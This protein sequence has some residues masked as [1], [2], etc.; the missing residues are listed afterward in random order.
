MIGRIAGPLAGPCAAF[1]S[2]FRWANFDVFP[3]IKFYPEPAGGII[4]GDCGNYVMNAFLMRLCQL[5]SSLLIV[6]VWREAVRR[7]FISR[8]PGTDVLP[9]ILCFPNVEVPAMLTMIYPLTD[10]I[11]RA[12]E[13][14]CTNW[15]I[16]ACIIFAFPVL[17]LLLGAFARAMYMHRTRKAE[18]VPPSLLEEP[19][20]QSAWGFFAVEGFRKVVMALILGLTVDEARAVL[21]CMMFGAYLGL[22][23]FFLPMQNRLFM[24]QCAL[25][26]CADTISVVFAA[27]PV[28]GWTDTGMASSNAIIFA[29]LSLMTSCAGLVS[30]S[31]ISLTPYAAKL[32]D[33]Y[34]EELDLTILSVMVDG[35]GASQGPA[36]PEVQRANTLRKSNHG[37]SVNPVMSENPLFPARCCYPILLANFLASHCRNEVDVLY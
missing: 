30:V 36:S 33:A 13:T 3:W 26:G 32:M 37:D 17:L 4:D 16:T 2:G 31:I 6:F 12:I 20:K 25:I 27:S 35:D 14:E 11:A 10:V 9:A 19:Y 5:S 7:V 29:L 18:G 23:S 15:I 28:Y 8:N 24:A 34:V 1:S 22:L 21:C